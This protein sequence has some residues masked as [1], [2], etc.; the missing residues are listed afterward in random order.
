MPAADAGEQ[1]AKV[2]LV[3]AGMAAFNAFRRGEL[4]AWLGAKFA[5]V[6]AAGT[7]AGPTML[8]VL[9]GGANRD[10]GVAVATGVGGAITTAG[11][12]AATTGATGATPA[13]L[14]DVAG[15]GRQSARFAAK[16][17]PLAEAAR[18]DGIVLTGSSWRSNERQVQLRAAH[19]CGGSRIYDSTCKGSPPTAVPG[20]SRHETGDAIDVT[21]TGAGG[22]NSPEFRWLAANAA[23]WGVHNLP[24]EPW[25][26]SIDGH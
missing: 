6:G 8:D 10:V 13:G 1:L 2:L 7:P 25:H 5:N 15:A 21:L 23:K 22:R 4:G 24:S 17:R 20:R 11:E 3:F 12:G 26:W 14:V 16:W 9:R 19:G 18:R